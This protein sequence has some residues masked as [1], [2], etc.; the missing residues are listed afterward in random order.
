MSTTGPAPQ[1]R[2]TVR[3]YTGGDGGITYEEERGY[4]WVLFAGTML[5]LLAT[6]NFIDG[7]AAV[8][9]SSFFVGNAKFVISDLKT[10]GWILI[11][12]AAIQ[13][14]TAIGVWLK[15]KGVRWVGVTIAGL[16]SI[17][18]L[19]FM[20]AYPFWS[21]SLFAVDILVMYGLIAHGRRAGI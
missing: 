7:I 21:L 6:V 20:P 3:Q 12:V 2:A 4:G 11:A 17:A 5:A 13:G 16:N 8:S 10:W 1:Q 9:K 19:M 15:W 14:V 18:Q